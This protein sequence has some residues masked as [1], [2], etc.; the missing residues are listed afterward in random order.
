MHRDDY[1]HIISPVVLYRFRT[2]FFV[3]MYVHRVRVFENRVMNKLSGP[4]R[5]EVQETGGNFIHG[6]S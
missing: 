5:E 2:F 3:S 1:L 4:K 6:A